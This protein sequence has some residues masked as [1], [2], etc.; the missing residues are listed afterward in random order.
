MDGQWQS[1]LGARRLANSQLPRYPLALL[2]PDGGVPHGG[3]ITLRF[4]DH[5]I[6]LQSSDD[7]GRSPGRQRYEHAEDPVP[8]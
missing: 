5:H 1:R 7:E 6:R 2:I 3:D 8:K 4:A